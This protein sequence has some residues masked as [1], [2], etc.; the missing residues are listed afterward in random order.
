[1]TEDEEPPV[2]TTSP[3]D[4]GGPGYWWY[5]AHNTI[6]LLFHGEVVF[7]CRE[8][9]ETQVR[10]VGVSILIGPLPSCPGP[11]HLARIIAGVVAKGIP[12][13][14]GPP[15]PITREQFVA[16]G[17]DEMTVVCEATPLPKPMKTEPEPS[18]PSEPSESESY[19]PHPRWHTKDEPPPT[20]A[21]GTREDGYVLWLRG[22][23]E[24]LVNG[25]DNPPAEWRA[26]VSIPKL[27]P[28]DTKVPL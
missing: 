15:T 28:S 14:M 6:T 2:L 26:W 21:D 17:Y 1:M 23:D 9:E 27:P 13:M 20:A 10:K 24:V 25:W 7:E 18:E 8:T 16:S 12:G 19:G 11:E 3:D 22:E 5:A 4:H